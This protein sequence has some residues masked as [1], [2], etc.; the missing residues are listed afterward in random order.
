VQ[1]ILLCCRF[2]V[3]G[4]LT[5]RIDATCESMSTDA[6]QAEK[7]LGAAPLLLRLFL[8]LFLLL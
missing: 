6:I 5:P 4:L 8:L 2:H 7:E 1:A 3:C